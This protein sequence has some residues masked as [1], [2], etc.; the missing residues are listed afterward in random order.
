MKLELE[1]KERECADLQVI[2]ELQGMLQRKLR[3]DARTSEA[4]CVS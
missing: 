3:V 4:H 2:S 1:L